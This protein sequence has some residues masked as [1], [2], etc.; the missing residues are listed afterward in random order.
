MDLM[1]TCINS[2]CPMKGDCKRTKSKPDQHQIMKKY[3]FKK[4]ESGK[5]YCSKFINI[6]GD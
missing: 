2:D 6:I 5:A 3:H 1:V 4:I